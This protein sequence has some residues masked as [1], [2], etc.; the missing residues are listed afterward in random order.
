MTGKSVPLGLRSPEP[1][2]WTPG[3]ARALCSLTRSVADRRACARSRAA[4]CFGRA[5][6]SQLV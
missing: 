2:P 4:G 3:P 6:D 5:G 1:S